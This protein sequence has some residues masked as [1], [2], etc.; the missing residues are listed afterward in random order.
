MQSFRNCLIN[1]LLKLTSPNTWFW[2]WICYIVTTN[3]STDG[4]LETSDAA[5]EEANQSEEELGIVTDEDENRKIAAAEALKKLDEV[6][7][8]KATI[9]I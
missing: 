5:A 8:A 6:K 1:F 7:L 9:W 3:W 4:R 2:H